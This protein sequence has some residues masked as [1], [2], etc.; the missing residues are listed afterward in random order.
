MEPE[1]VAAFVAE[2]NAEWNRLQGE[3][4]AHEGA[5]RRE[6]DAV[7]RK[8]D[9]LINAI[10]DG[11]RAPGLQQKLDELTARQ[12][13]LERALQAAPRPRPL[14]HPRLADIYRQRVESLQTRLVPTPCRCLIASAID[15]PRAR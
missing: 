6:L 8:L 15:T 5:K 1:H 13:E 7:G 3:A 2:F 11:L 10:A 12:A 14:L 4:S 9:G